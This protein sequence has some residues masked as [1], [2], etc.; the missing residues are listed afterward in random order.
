MN[1]NEKSFHIS[2][3]QTWTIKRGGPFSTH[4]SFNGAPELILQL[5]REITKPQLQEV[6]ASDK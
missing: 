1:N 6:Q 3:V 2:A 5:L 4:G